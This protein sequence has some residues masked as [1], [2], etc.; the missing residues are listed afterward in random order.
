MPK[1]IIYL[2]LI[3]ILCSC[4]GTN[5][6][7]E[8]CL[9]PHSYSTD[10]L[11]DTKYI[12]T[13]GDTDFYQSFYDR[14]SD[15]CAL[16]EMLPYALIMANKYNYAPAYSHVFEIFTHLGGCE[17]GLEV[18]DSATRELAISYFKEAVYAEYFYA[19]EKLLEDFCD[20]C[21]YPIKE[22]YTD[23]ALIAKAIENISRAK[24]E[25]EEEGF[26]E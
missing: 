26:L 19:S 11:H 20:T 13:T 21:P 24:N 8:I 23:S 22:L 7:E 10:Y 14:Y 1:K 18:L 9:S 5:E 3:L 2:T 15:D 4:N 25:T 16:D 17:M 6:V 12:V